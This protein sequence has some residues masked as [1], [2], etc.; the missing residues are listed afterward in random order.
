MKKLR[1]KQIRSG[2]G[3]P[4]DQRRTLRGLRLGKP[5]SSAELQDTPAVRG[6]IFKVRHLVALE[7]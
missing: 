3:F 6:M 2:V 4:E 1:V 5:G 7:D